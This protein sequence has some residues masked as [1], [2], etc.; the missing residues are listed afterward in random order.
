[1]L[2]YLSYKLVSDDEFR[3]LFNYTR[4]IIKAID[5]DGLKLNEGQLKGPYTSLNH[6]KTTLDLQSRFKIIEAEEK[7]ACKDP[8]LN[9]EATITRVYLPW[10]TLSFIQA[11]SHLAHRARPI[12]GH[13][14]KQL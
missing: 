3:E 2:E 13:E 1:M 6:A 14:Q 12:P 7:W 4:I 9:R 8:S 11:S 10:V 5:K